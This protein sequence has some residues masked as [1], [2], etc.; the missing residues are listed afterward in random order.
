MTPYFKSFLYSKSFLGL[1]SSRP[2]V[3]HVFPVLQVFPGPLVFP[4]PR[5]SRLSST[6]CT[7]GLSWALVSPYFTS[8]LYSQS[9]L[10]LWSSHP[11]VL[12]L[13]PVLFVLQVFSRPLVFLFPCTLCLSST[14]CTPRRPAF[15]YLTH[16]QL[17]HC[18]SRHHQKL[19][20]WI[21]NSKKPTC[22][23][24]EPPKI[25]DLPKFRHP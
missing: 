2:P 10:G 3:L 5:A 13:I 11:P 16:P 12:H 8:F 9:F 15:P 1:W 4:S 17:F 22:A 23:L 6:L 18:L 25:P 20:S 14:L 19:L 24:F 21:S 7:A